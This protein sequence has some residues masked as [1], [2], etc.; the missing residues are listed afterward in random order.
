MTAHHHSWDRKGQLPVGTIRTC[1]SC[2]V[3][4]VKQA[5]PAGGVAWMQPAWLKPADLKGTR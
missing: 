5:R 2:G 4:Q 3:R 1:N